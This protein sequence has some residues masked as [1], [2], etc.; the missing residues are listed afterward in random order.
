MYTVNLTVIDHLSVHVNTI[1]TL[2][3]LPIS[4]QVVDR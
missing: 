3:H 1:D 2:S 4:L